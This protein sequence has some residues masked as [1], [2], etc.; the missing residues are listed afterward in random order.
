MIEI[1]PIRHD[2][3]PAAKRLIYTVAKDVFHDPLPVDEMMEK[4][5]AG[6]ALEDMNDIQANYFENGGIFLVTTDQGRLIGTGAI[7][8]STE[9]ICEL[10]R[11]WLLTE[12]HGR[13]LGY[14]MMAELLAF[15]R[16]RGYTRIQLETDAIH[17][18]RAVGFYKRL[19]FYEVS[20]PRAVEDEDIRMEMVL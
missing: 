17:Q 4:Y 11:L 7:R 6:G 16:S 9:E 5:G 3:W 1:R 13:G 18:K 8:S 14:R 15:A 2:E 19:G 12:Y 20:V 10:K